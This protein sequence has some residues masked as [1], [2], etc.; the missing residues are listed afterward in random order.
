MVKKKTEILRSAGAVSAGT[1]ARLALLVAA[2]VNNSLAVFGVNPLSSA[3]RTD[4]II[5]TV[6]MI[7]VSLL[8][9]WKNNS[10]TSAARM[11]DEYM[12]YLREED[13]RRH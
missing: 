5:V 11:A 2:L 3:G 1:W 13:T 7:L 8:A 10:F 6:S 9:Y 12:E 4:D